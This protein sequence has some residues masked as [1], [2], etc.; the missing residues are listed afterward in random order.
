MYKLQ[1]T[2]YNKLAYKLW[3]WD[4]DKQ[5]KVGRLHVLN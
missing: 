1:A 2:S 3:L 5:F 4:S